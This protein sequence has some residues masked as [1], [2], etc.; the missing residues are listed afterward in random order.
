MLAYN[1][2]V[3]TSVAFAKTKSKLKVEIQ[4]LVNSTSVGARWTR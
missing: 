3:I 4:E 2:H 1:I